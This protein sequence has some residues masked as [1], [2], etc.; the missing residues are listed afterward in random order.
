[1]KTADEARDV[2]AYLLPRA[3]LLALIRTATTGRIQVGEEVLADVLVPLQIPNREGILGEV[4]AQLPEVLHHLYIADLIERSALEMGV[5]VYSVPAAV[6][7]R[8]ITAGLDEALASAGLEE[9]KGPV[10]PMPPRPGLLETLLVGT[11]ARLAGA[12]AV[13]AAA[14]RRWLR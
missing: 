6:M 3:I 12:Q 13:I 5:V 1:M 4:R 8:L 2:A 7:M 10:A 9:R 14:R 11:E